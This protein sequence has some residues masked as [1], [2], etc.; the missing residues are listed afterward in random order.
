M[1]KICDIPIVIIDKAKKLLH[2]LDGGRL[3]QVGSGRYLTKICAYLPSS[4]K[5][6]KVFDFTHPKV[7]LSMLGVQ[8][9]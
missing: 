4:Y 3:R 9:A 8:L 5:V 7:T 1:R 2:M 6:S